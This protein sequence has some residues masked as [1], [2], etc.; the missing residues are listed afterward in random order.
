M[1]DSSLSACT[2]AVIAAEVGHLDLAVRYAA[3]AALIDLDDL[4]HNARDGL[5]IAALSGAW[6]ALVGGFGGMR[7]DDPELAFRP[8]LPGTWQRLCFTVRWR[9]S[10]ITV[11]IRPGEATYSVDGDPVA[12][13]HRTAA[14]ARGADV[15]DRHEPRT[16]RRGRP[17]SWLPVVPLTPE[18]QQPAGRAPA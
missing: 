7:D 16:G 5:H 14:P 10:R 9:T 6:I 13:R 18:P 3:E 11:E 8:Q 12:I 17:W 15:E 1:R 4:E 2:Q